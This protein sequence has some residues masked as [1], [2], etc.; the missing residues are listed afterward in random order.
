MKLR[1]GIIG[2]SGG[3]AFQA[4]FDCLRLSGHLI[5][6]IVLVDRDC[7]LLHWANSQNH[8]VYKIKYSNKNQFSIEAN[9]IFHDLGCK[10]VLLFFTRLVSY[11][12]IMD[13]RVWNIHPSLLPSF[14]GLNAVERALEAKV[15]LLGA[16]LHRVDAGIDTGPIICQVATSLLPHT[17][18]SR[19][20]R[21]S[22]IQKVWLTLNWFEFI[23]YS[24]TPTS[25]TYQQI[26]GIEFTTSDLKNEALK[27]FFFRWLTKLDKTTT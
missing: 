25:S 26:S 10:D 15:P 11:P 1:I 17:H 24:K 23:F 13:L 5:E 7:G 4:A 20:Q 3:S 6:P 16:T 19:A 21:L 12:L 22:Y 9:S 27:E 2:S 18:P 8:S 14:T